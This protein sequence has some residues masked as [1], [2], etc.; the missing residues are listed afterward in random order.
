MSMTAR[1]PITIIIIFS[2]V[3]RFIGCVVFYSMI[4]V[5][6]FHSSSQQPFRLITQIGLC[7]VSCGFKNGGTT[8]FEMAVSHYII[9]GL[10]N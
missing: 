2:V 8:R 6:L 3:K 5:H 10:K 4:Y 7:C 1:N 9:L